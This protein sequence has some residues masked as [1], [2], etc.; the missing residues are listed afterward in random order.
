MKI[1]PLYPNE[2]GNLVLVNHQKIQLHQHRAIFHYL[3]KN[4]VSRYSYTSFFPDKKMHTYTDV[5]TGREIV[6]GL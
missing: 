2:I 4:A 3:F 6:G 5:V 1:D